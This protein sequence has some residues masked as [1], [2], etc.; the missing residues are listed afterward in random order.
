VLSSLL[1]VGGEAAL[2][3]KISKKRFTALFKNTK[4]PLVFDGTRSPGWCSGA[5]SRRL[6]MF[7]GTRLGEGAVDTKPAMDDAQNE[8]NFSV[9]IF[10]KNKIFKNIL[11][12]TFL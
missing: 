12:Y 11:L 5:T 8:A 2:F 4:D 1:D 7:T 9:S 3:R 6:E 10:V